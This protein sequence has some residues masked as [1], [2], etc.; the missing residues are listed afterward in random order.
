VSGGRGYSLHGFGKG[1]D[2]CA[3]VNGNIS[4]PC[5][6]A[7]ASVLQFR[8]NKII[9][10]E[11]VGDAKGIES[12]GSNISVKVRGVRKEWNSLGLFSKACGTTSCLVTDKC[13]TMVR[14]LY[15][16]TRISD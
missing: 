6:L 13:K 8:F 3:E 9:S 2:A 4:E 11:V 7:D 16:S 15:N 14:Y 1:V 12:V 5:K 10:W